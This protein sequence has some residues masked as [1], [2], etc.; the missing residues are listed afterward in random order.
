LNP[1]KKSI[2]LDINVIENEN[3]YPMVAPG[4]STNSMLGLKTES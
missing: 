2:V 3:C 1:L 4:K